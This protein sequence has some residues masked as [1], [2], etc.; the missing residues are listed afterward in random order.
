VEAEAA[1]EPEL[2][3]WLLEASEEE[4]PGWK[5]EEAAIPAESLLDINQASLVELEKLPGVGF[6][7]AQRILDH[8]MTFGP[9]S[10]VEDLVK[11]AGFSSANLEEIRRL[12]T[13]A[14]AVSFPALTPAFDA[15][16]WS[17]TRKKEEEAVRIPEPASAPESTA[18]ATPPA[19]AAAP[20]PIV[21]IEPVQPPLAIPP[22]E[23]GAEIGDEQAIILQARN[24]LLRNDVEE[25]AHHYGILIN[26]GQLLEVVIK[27]LK[28]ALYDHPVDPALWTALGDAQ[29]RNNQLQEALDSYTKAEELLR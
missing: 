21:Q 25:T 19:E 10:S 22:F 5:P 17:E 20:E 27:D 23:E 14:P 3:A 8:R 13:V 6:I 1:A 28:Q 26:R 16:M 7:L 18:P 2:P 15:S 4:E 9:F 12:I 11:V 29:A 24:A